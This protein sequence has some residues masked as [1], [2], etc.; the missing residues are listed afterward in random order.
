MLKEKFV[1][2]MKTKNRKT[3][4]TPRQRLPAFRGGPET[5]VPGA[6]GHVD[7]AI[8]ISNSGIVLRGWFVHPGTEIREMAL[9][10]ARG[11][12][13]ITPHGKM[14]LSNGDVV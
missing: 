11:R 9:V 12:R 5:T 8:R 13:V 2:W 6:R 1:N 7:E 4:T 10:G 3:V 14:D